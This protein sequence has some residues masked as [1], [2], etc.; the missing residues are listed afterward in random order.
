MMMSQITTKDLNYYMLLR[1]AIL[2][3][4]EEDGWSATIPDLKGCLAVGDTIQEALELLED[5]KLSWISASLEQ[6]LLIPEP[7]K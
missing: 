1:Y 6:H 5:A 4:P 7:Q 3:R 2:I